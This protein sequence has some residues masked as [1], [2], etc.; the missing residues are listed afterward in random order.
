MADA[1][2]SSM[3]IMIGEMRGQLRELIHGFN[4]LSQAMMGLQSSVDKSAH[5]PGE[6]AELKLRIA[7]LEARMSVIEAEKNQRAGAMSLGSALLRSPAIAW[8]AALGLG[9]LA[10]FERKSG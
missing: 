2:D 7:A 1:S 3:P 6:L 10:Y 9:V 4:N 8:L 5:L